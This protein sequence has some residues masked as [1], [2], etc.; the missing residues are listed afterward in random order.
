MAFDDE[1]DRGQMPL[2]V[3]GLYVLAGCGIMAGAVAWLAS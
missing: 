1:D 2:W 3:L